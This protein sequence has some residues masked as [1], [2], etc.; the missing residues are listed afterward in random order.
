MTL[1]TQIAGILGATALALATPLAAQQ[2]PPPQIAA[3]DVTDAQVVAFVDAILAVDA[4][5][6]EYGTQIEGA[7]DEAAKQALV[8]EANAAAADAV[9]EVENITIDSYVAIANAAGESDALN[10][11]IVARISE[12][13]EQ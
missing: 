9:D 4:V 7:D 10:Q 1:K 6:T 12:V 2:T 3:E 11:R 13:R 5:R 8:E